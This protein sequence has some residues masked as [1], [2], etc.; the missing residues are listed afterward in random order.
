MTSVN[1]TMLTQKT[2]GGSALAGVKMPEYLTGESLLAYCELRLGDLDARIKVHMGTQDSALKQR[3]AVDN[4]TSCLSQFGS[5]GPTTVKQVDDCRIGLEAA[6]KTLPDGDPIRDQLL[7]KAAEINHK[8]I[9][10]PDPSHLVVTEGQYDRVGGT[11]EPQFAKQA[12]GVWDADVQTVK[13]IG[14]EVKGNA[15]LD[16]IELQTL[17]SQRQ[18]AVQMTTN[19]MSK[20][21]QTA[22][23]IVQK[24]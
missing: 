24:I 8:Y 3:Q 23:S 7:A 4:A 13:K 14:D 2:T 21:D 18:M 12:D 20:L 17:V 11:P 9:F 5:A 16:M 10:T 15:E 1:T 6:A 22:E 19:L